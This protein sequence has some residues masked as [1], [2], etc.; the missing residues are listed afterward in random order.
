MEDLVI[1]AQVG[2][3]SW[4]SFRCGAE[5]PKAFDILTP[6]SLVHH[7][8]LVNIELL[9]LSELVCDLPPPSFLGLRRISQHG[10]SYLCGQLDS[11]VYELNK[12]ALGS[13][14]VVKDHD[15]EK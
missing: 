6:L 7:G 10:Q 9:S 15:V 3:W 8:E 14:H 4:L 2:S 5:V 1:G 13:V 11:L 12:V